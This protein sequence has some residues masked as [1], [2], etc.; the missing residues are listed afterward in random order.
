MPLKDPLNL[1]NKNRKITTIEMKI[2]PVKAREYK[3]IQA[4]PQQSLVFLPSLI[5]ARLTKEI[6]TAAQLDSLWSNS[7]KAKLV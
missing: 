2:A 7:T 3:E 6:K 5:K 1:I 4:Q